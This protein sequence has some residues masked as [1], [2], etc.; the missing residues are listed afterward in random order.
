[1]GSHS[2]NES[3]ST[4]E[5][6]NNLVL[7]LQP[8][9]IS[10]PRREHLFLFLGLSAPQ[11]VSNPRHDAPTPGQWVRRQP[12]SRILKRATLLGDGLFVFSPRCLFSCFCLGPFWGQK[13]PTRTRDGNREEWLV[14]VSQS[15]AFL[16]LVVWIEGLEVRGGGR[17]PV[18]MTTTMCSNSQTT[19]PNLQAKVP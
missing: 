1:M 2:V 9:R 11:S 4:R 16:Q 18:T 14:G 13:G 7:N 17:F 10:T 3:I 12:C 8:Q 5:A 6:L 19:N 15:L